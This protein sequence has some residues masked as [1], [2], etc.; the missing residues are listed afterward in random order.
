MLLKNSI[1]IYKKNFFILFKK[2][3]I[4]KFQAFI[5]NAFN[6]IK[7]M[8]NAKR[9]NKYKKTFQQIKKE[10]YRISKTNIQRFFENN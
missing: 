5:Y 3:N 1:Q 7:K 8:D 6:Y 4:T 10:M 9:Y 2:K